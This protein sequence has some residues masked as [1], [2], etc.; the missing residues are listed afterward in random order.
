MTSP[1]LS[2]ADPDGER[3]EGLF[4]ERTQLAW[5]RSGLALVAAFAI[6]TRRVWSSGTA[7]GDA[8]AITF[9]AV[10]TLGWAI[11]MLGWGLRHRGRVEPRPRSPRELF[12]VAAGTTA[13]AVAGL[14]V[15]LVHP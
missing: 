3:A 15:A 11:G 9:L 14:V 1:S 8:V 7:T 12:A 2:G 4:T 5:T 10:A 13:L 6:L